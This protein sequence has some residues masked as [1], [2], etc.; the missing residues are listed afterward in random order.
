MR[1]A[2]EQQGPAAGSVALVQLILDNG[3]HILLI[4]SRSDIPS[5]RLKFLDKRP[6]CLSLGLSYRARWSVVA[7]GP[8]HLRLNMYR[9]GSVRH[10]RPKISGAIVVPGG[11]DNI[12]GIKFEPYGWYIGTGNY[13]EDMLPIIQ[14]EL[15]AC[16]RPARR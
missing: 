15:D 14:D 13:E 6:L 12:F 7:V 3:Q 1:R 10:I 4:V 11:A 2:H 9:I 8:F 16:S 5:V